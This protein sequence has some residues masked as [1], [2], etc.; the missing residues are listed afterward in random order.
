MT[1]CHVSA[2]TPPTVRLP[3]A[4]VGVRHRSLWLYFW[5]ERDG[6]GLSGWWMT[7]DAVGGDEF[8]FYC[9]EGRE[10]PSECAVG[11][12]RCPRFEAELGR[13]L[14]LGFRAAGDGAVAAVGSDREAVVLPDGVSSVQLSRLVFKPAGSNH[15]KP[16]YVAHELPRGTE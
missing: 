6:A 4:G 13:E 7:P 11:G 9:A 12:W 10:V 15:G 5:D 14:Q 3:T 2:D 16:L 1:G 8:F